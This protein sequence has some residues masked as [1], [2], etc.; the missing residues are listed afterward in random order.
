MPA[1][2]M[3]MPATQMNS[4][5]PTLPLSNNMLLGV[6]KIPVPIIRLKMLWIH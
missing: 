6:V 3:S 4:A 1:A 2:A 5:N